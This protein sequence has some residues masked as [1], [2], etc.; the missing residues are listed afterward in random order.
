MTGGAEAGDSGDDPD[1]SLDGSVPEDDLDAA[2][3]GSNQYSNAS[4][5]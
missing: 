1:P 5:P 2:D 4:M 3:S